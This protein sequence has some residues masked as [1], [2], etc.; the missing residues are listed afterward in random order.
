MRAQQ[1]SK[2][3]EDCSVLK[4]TFLLFKTNTSFSFASVIFSIGILTTISFVSIYNP[5]KIITVAGPLV[6]SAA[7]GTPNSSHTVLNT[8]IKPLHA[9]ELAIP[10]K[11]KSSK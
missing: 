3:I 6:F 10:T 9:R 4:V 5:R 7:K 11:K 2:P 1:L 8:D